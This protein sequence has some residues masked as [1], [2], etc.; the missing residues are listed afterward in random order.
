MYFHCA[1]EGQVLSKSSRPFLAQSQVK[2]KKVPDVRISAQSQRTK[3]VFSPSDDVYTYT[4]FTPG[5]F[6]ALVCGGAAPVA[7]L[8]TSL[9]MEKL[10][11]SHASHVTFLF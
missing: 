2:R 8:N 3:K 9:T 1:K 11:V 5:K 6:C 7:P 10:E 4:T